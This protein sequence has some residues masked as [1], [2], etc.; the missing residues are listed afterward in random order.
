MLVLKRGAGDADWSTHKDVWL[1]GV[2]VTSQ[3]E[4]TIAVPIIGL[5]QSE[6]NLLASRWVP[7]NKRH[8]QTPM[9]D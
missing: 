9:G 3:R 1:F 4:S 5:P 6:S 2:N 7:S 8:Q